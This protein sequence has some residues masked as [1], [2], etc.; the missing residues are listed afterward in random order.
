MVQRHGIGLKLNEY[1]AS[2]GLLFQPNAF[3]EKDALFAND[4]FYG[5]YGRFTLNTQKQGQKFRTY[6]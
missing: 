2:M 6:G 5:Y 1:F 4:G 3:D